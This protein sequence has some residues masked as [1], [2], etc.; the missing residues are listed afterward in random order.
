[1]S[2]DLKTKTVLIADYGTHTELA[3]RLAREFKE[4]KLWV[5]WA[6]AYPKA[7][8]AM[9]GTGIEDVERVESFWD[10]APDADLIVFP[11]LNMADMARV[12]LGRLNKPVWSHLGAE[13]L[14]LDRW[15]AHKTKRG[16]GIASP[17]TKH[18]AGIDALAAVLEDTE[19]KWVKVSCY[20][21]DA[22]TFFHDSKQSVDLHVAY[23][24][25]KMG[26]VAET[27]EFVVEEY[28]EGSPFS[29]DGFAVQGGWPETSYCGT[30]SGGAYIGKLMNYADV[31]G[32]VTGICEELTP[33]LKEEGA[34]GFVSFDTRLRDTEAI[35]VGQKMRCCAP[36]F[37]ALM[38]GYDNLG[39]ILWE[40]AHGRLAPVRSAGTFVVAAPIR[41]SR[42]A[43]S[44]VLVDAPDEIER[45][46]KLRNKAVIG[47]KT[48]HVPTTGGSDVIGAVVAVADDLESAIKTIKKRAAQV[49]GYRVD[50]CTDGLDA[51]KDAAK[52]LKKRGVDF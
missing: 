22:E 10:H 41:S 43:D 24:R 36:Q 12:C 20:K 7:A 37:F 23:L 17:A 11:D 47:G 39:E 44:W 40:G 9:I 16:V 51:A 35:L 48:Y 38:E 31:P 26:P 14:E 46:V 1:M 49:K 13:N 50:V 4:V 27:C 30:E 52:E 3:P 6:S 15:G 45:W 29:Y 42:A 18:C 32:S 2:D 34:S 28:V 5:P 21:G 8:P 19:D 33:I 25:Y